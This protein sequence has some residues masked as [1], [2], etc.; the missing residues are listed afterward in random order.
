M[1]TLLFFVSI[2]VSRHK[3]LFATGETK[4]SI[5]ISRY[6]IY[7]KQNNNKSFLKI[8]ILV[9]SR[10]HGGIS[11]LTIFFPAVPSVGEILLEMISTTTIILDTSLFLIPLDENLI[12]GICLGVLND[13]LQCQNGHNYCRHC[14]AEY[15]DDGGKPCPLRCT[16]ML[17][18]TSDLIKN[19][20]LAGIIDNLEIQCPTTISGGECMWSGATSSWKIHQKQCLFE[21]VMCDIEGCCD[22]MLRG[23]LAEHR[24]NCPHRKKPCIWCHVLFS[25]K[26]LVMHCCPE[27]AMSCPH[28]C[29]DANGNEMQCLRRDMHQHLLFDCPEEVIACPFTPL[30]CHTTLPRKEMSHHQENTA[31]AVHQTMLLTKVLEQEHKLMLQKTIIDDLNTIASTEIVFSIQNLNRSQTYASPTVEYLGRL[32]QVSFAAANMMHNNNSYHNIVLHCSC[33]LPTHLRCLT[34]YLYQQDNKTSSRHSTLSTSFSPHTVVTTTSTT[35]TLL[36]EQSAKDVY[37]FP[38]GVELSSLSS[39]A[40]PPSSSSSVSSFPSSATADVTTTIHLAPR[41]ETFRGS[42]DSDTEAHLQHR[43]FLRDFLVANEPE[44]P[45]T[46]WQRDDQPGSASGSASNVDSM[47]CDASGA[48]WEMSNFIKTEDLLSYVSASPGQSLIVSV[49]MSIVR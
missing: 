36:V 7:S 13:P 49:K 28:G 31:I 47:A 39:S 4:N 41:D 38:S 24:E 10:L 30:G 26:Q 20:A 17:Y 40:V 33:D 1:K 45:T 43:S 3:T 22:T 23:M 27:E 18:S 37:F 44:R 48:V 14:V 21:S 19:R 5:S 15:L 6:H 29:C 35:N 12:C 16:A 25:Q 9:N 32:F 34:G 11:C 8:T 46:Q 2:F 42:S